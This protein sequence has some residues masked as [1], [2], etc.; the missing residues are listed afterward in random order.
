[1]KDNATKT[2][3]DRRK[4]LLGI[5]PVCA[6]PCM[7]MTGLY[8]KSVDSKKIFSENDE[9]N[10]HKFDKPFPRELTI[11]QF[12]GVRF[13]NQ[14]RLAKALKKEMGEEKSIEFIKDMTEK[15]MFEY[16]KSQ[17]EQSGD[18]SF[19]GFIDQFKSPRFDDL[20]T[21]EIIEDTEKVFEIKVTEC[22]WAETFLKREA[23]DI[24][25]ASVCH[26]DYYWPKGYNS[27]MKMVRD[28]TLMQGYECCNHRYIVEE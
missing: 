7:A 18:N 11:R 16:G 5:A 12:Y 26:G 22:I 25:F 28:K 27:K 8:A 15:D 4:F 2:K 1:M 17:A 9:D 6:I 24:G 14:I 3:I 21:M 23:G 19:K 10:V 13:G 20:L